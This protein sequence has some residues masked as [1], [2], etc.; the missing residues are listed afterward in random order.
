MTVINQQMNE[1]ATIELNLSSQQDC[2]S[3][4]AR[5]Y[6]QLRFYTNVRNQTK[7]NDH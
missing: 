6:L 2:A 4:E 5:I 3:I 7:Q 1:Y